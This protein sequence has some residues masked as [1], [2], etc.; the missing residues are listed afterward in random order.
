MLG[1][2]GQIHP[3]VAD[4]VGLSPETFLARLTI[5]DLL[6]I[7]RSARKLAP[8]SRNPAVRRDMAVLV[9][10]SV[11]FE[12]MRE[13][14]VEACGEV[15]ERLWVFDVFGGSSLPEGTHSVGVALQLRKLGQNLT[16]EEANQVRDRAAKALESLGARLR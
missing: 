3:D 12:A 6:A 11:P 15:L 4:Q 13:R 2:C 14:I 7:P 16:D 5:D 9:S 1:H 10:K 8:V